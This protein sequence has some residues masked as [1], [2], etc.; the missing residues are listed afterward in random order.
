MDAPVLWISAANEDGLDALEQTIRDMF[1]QGMIAGNDEVVITNARQKIMSVK[2][3]RKPEA[4]RGG[5]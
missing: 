4:C 5:H 1:E 3:L 2:C